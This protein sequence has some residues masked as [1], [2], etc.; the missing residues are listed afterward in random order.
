MKYVLLIPPH[1]ESWQGPDRGR[2]AMDGA[3]GSGVVGERESKRG[4]LR[5]AGLEGGTEEIGIELLGDKDEIGG[6]QLQMDLPGG[7]DAVELRHADIEGLLNRDAAIGGS[8][9]VSKSA[10]S[11]RTKPSSMSAWSSAIRRR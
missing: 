4:S 8:A 9:D 5:C 6:G 10:E 1:R 7:L 11:R 2:A 3:P